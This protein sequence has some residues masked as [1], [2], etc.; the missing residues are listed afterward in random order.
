MTTNILKELLI[1]LQH[2]HLMK[3][4]QRNIILQLGNTLFKPTKDVSSC[5][6]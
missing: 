4:P 5:W 1:R 2:H 3:Q 6:A